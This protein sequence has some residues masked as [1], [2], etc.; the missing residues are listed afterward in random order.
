MFRSNRNNHFCSRL[1]FAKRGIFTLCLIMLAVCMTRIA[2]HAQTITASITGTVTDPA[3]KAVKDASV[4]AKNTDTGLS[5]P[6]KTNHDGVYTINYLP[7]GPYTLQIMANGFKEADFSSFTL[8]GGQVAR[9]DGSL[10]VGSTSEAIIVTTESPLINTQNAELSTTI[11]ASMLKELPLVSDNIM[12]LAL[13]T[14]GVVVATPSTLDSVS[15]SSPLSSFNAAG[16]REQS[17]NFTL[18]GVDINNAVDNYLGYSVNRD[19]LQEFRIITGNGNAEYGNANGGQVVMVT[20]SGTNKYHGSASVQFQNTLMNANSWLAKNVLPGTAKTPRASQNRDFYSGTLGG[21]LIPDKLF[22]FADYRGVR[23]HVTT[24]V[25]SSQ[26]DPAYGGNPLFDMTGQAGLKGT[27]TAYDPTLGKAVPITNPAAKYLLAHPEIYPTC[28]QSPCSTSIKSLSSNY[29]GYQ[30]VKTQIDQGDVKLDWRMDARD[31]LSGRYSMARYYINYYKVPTPTTLPMNSSYPYTGF[32]V[33]WDRVI[34]PNIVNEARIGYSRSLFIQTATDIDGYWGN[35]G[36]SKLGIP[37]PVGSQ[38]AEGFPE[39]VFAGTGP[40][41]TSIGSPSANT[42]RTF[43]AFNYSDDLSW[44]LG[45][46]ELKIGGIL[47]RYQENVYFAGTTTAGALGVF[48]F[49]GSSSAVSSTGS[50][51]SDFLQDKASTYAIGSQTGEWGQRQWRPALYVQDNWKLKPDLTV[52]MGLRW[53]YDSPYTEVNNKQAN[54]D[55]ATG[56]VTVAGTD[57]AS[58]TLYDSYW[59]GFM[60]R[61]GF[62]Y[63][64]TALRNRFVIRGGFG[65]TNYFEGLGANQRLTMN[66]MFVFNAVPSANTTAPYA[67]EN[68]FGT[69]TPGIAQSTSF[70]AWDTHIKPALTQQYDLLLGYQLSNSTSVQLGY[71]GQTGHHLISLLA[72]NQ[73]TCSTIPI[74]NQETP[75]KVPMLSTFPKLAAGGFHYTES[76]AVMNYNALQATLTQHDFH[77]LEMIA[78]Y[79][80]GK[81]MTDAPGFY[82]TSGVP[83]AYNAY[84][85]DSYNLAGEY[86]AAYFDAT[87]I[88][89][90]AVVYRLPIG[91][92]KLIG[93]GWNHWLDTGLGGWSLGITAQYRTGFPIPIISTSYYSPSGHGGYARANKYRPL[94]VVHRG[95]RN[96]QN[97]RDIMWFGNDPSAEGVATKSGTTTYGTTGVLGRTGSSNSITS[98]STISGTTCKTLS[99]SPLNPSASAY[100]EYV[101]I[102]GGTKTCV[103]VFTANDN[104]VSAYG[105]ELTTGFG[106]SS[107]STERMPGYH[108][109]SASA[110]KAFAIRAGTSIAFRADAYNLLNSVSLAAPNNNISSTSFGQITNT[111]STERRLQLSLKLLF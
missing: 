45:K 33:N 68:G 61:V 73:A 95:I 10:K 16:N 108:D 109:L 80:Y 29:T 89:S 64:P 11:S 62:A 66:P 5:F 51:W 75:C 20:K 104:G 46:H 1:D 65:I 42:R 21:R 87:H 83:G 71:A 47:L 6:T 86:G 31:Q 105:E 110:S 37:Y 18:D 78:N 2:G 82:G 8:I 94:K 60:P 9:F 30:G 12:G 4:V 67:V 13:L 59:G 56:K 14:P 3:G 23:Q 97:A 76:G 41:L 85:Q 17:N 77:G 101:S 40:S 54:V 70:S 48:T 7:V 102:N 32:V 58:R 52:N 22:F 50:Y 81:A 84:P 43:N 27:G 74:P 90:G 28:N 35:S 26:P 69:Y 98:G 63:S 103:N 49:T 15:A 44:Q 39:M 53:E 99:S 19:A 57:G 93:T 24:V 106:T 107:V 111:S 25:N 91:R 88:V 92:G 55:P 38:T 36:F 96:A 34:S 72:L 79:S 100:P